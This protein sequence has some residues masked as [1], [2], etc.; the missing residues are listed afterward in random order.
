MNSID[1]IYNTIKNIESI[2]CRLRQRMIMFINSNKGVYSSEKDVKTFV[3]YRM[4][5]NGYSIERCTLNT[6]KVDIL[7]SLLNHS[8]TIDV[9]HV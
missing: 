5:E 4:Q 2:K 6:D 7:H 1:K 8:K 9:L 3:S